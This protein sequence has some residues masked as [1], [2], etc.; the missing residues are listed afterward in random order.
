MGKIEDPLFH[1]RIEVD[2]GIQKEVFREYADVFGRG[3]IRVAAEKLGLKESTFHAYLKYQN[4]SVPTEIFYEVAGSLGLDPIKLIKKRTTLR[5]IRAK[6][7]ENSWKNNR[8]HMLSEAK[9]ASNLGIKKLEEIFGENWREDVTE[10]AREGWKKKYGDEWGKHF[11]SIGQEKARMKYGDDWGKKA[12]K[13]ATEILKETYGEKYWEKL[14]PMA[15]QALK[16]KY[17]PDW[18]TRLSRLGWEALERKYG[19]GWK[20]ITLEKARRKLEEKYGPNAH[21][22]IARHGS[23]APNIIESINSG[24]MCPECYSNNI[25]TDYTYNEGEATCQS[26][27]LV[28]SDKV[29]NEGPEWRAFDL[30]Q[31]ENR[32][33][34]GPPTTFTI[35]D[36]GLGTVIDWRDRDIYG[37]SSNPEQKA[38]N[39]RLRKWQRRTRVSNSTERNLSTALTEINKICSQLNLPRNILETAS[40][41]YTKAAKQHLLRGRNAQDL[42]VA[43]V[44]TACRQCGLSRSIEEVAQ[45]SNVKKEKVEHDY[46]SLVKELNY[47][48]KPTKPDQYITNFFNKLGMNGDVEE[49]A[50]RILTKA[51]ELKLTSGRSPISMAAAVSYIS[52]ILYN[53]RATQREIA[54]IANITEV[55]VRNRYKELDER[56]LFEIKV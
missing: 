12:M 31:H 5:K 16:E 54:E 49:T 48:I 35:H 19:P 53:T 10:I 47:N 9:K 55:T 14:I 18:K 37:K 25:I 20:E 44:Y 33:R 45:V 29:M 50:Y 27:G 21:K 43:A 6:Y 17:G 30:E 1:D 42:T 41:I 38:Q 15:H 56:L 22:I 28:L 11:S 51:K 2:E 39:Y 32:S 4:K 8:E 46:R 36:K 26:C 7:L 40:T 13:K 23:N 24:N 34:V 3:Y 52:S